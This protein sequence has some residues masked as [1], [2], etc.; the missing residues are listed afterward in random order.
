MRAHTSGGA[1]T[2]LNA[3]HL[4]RSPPCN[5]ATNTATTA[6]RDII[7]ALLSQTEPGRTAKVIGRCTLSVGPNRQASEMAGPL[8]ERAHPVLLE[9]CAFN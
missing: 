9:P 7:R 5:K 1:G 3:P 2:A 6:T 4:L 8:A